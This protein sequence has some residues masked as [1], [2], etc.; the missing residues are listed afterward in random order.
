MNKYYPIDC[1]KIVL[2]LIILLLH[3]R[4]FLPIGDTVLQ[5]AFYNLSVPLF[6]CFSGFFFARNINCK[7]S[8]HHLGVLYLIW[9]VVLWPLCISRFKEIDFMDRIIF[10][11][12]SGFVPTGWFIIALMWCMAITTLIWKIKDK[13]IA[14]ALLTVAGIICFTYCSLRN[15]YS[16][17]EVGQLLY[18]HSQETNYVLGCLFWSFPRG[19]LYFV[20]G[21]AF[22]RLQININRIAAWIAV[23]AIL[24]LFIFETQH[25]ID[26]YRLV[27]VY[28]PLSNPLLVS[29][30]MA[31][32]LSYCRPTP[33]VA[34]GKMLRE[35]S[36]MLYMAH[37]IIMYTV[38]RL[39]GIRIGWMFA[40]T[41]LLLFAIL[42][43]SYLLL[44]NR[45]GF[46]FLKYAV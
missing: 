4:S 6:F 23:I 32:L 46:S 22:M 20:I 3:T 31:L 2:A 17:T 39:T 19:M 16:Q 1:A 15:A 38:S 25:I 12:T 21:F 24:V 30:I 28:A 14:A 29:A 33:H 18:G 35:A 9:L 41:I 27:N 43:Y 11:V 36:T 26:S 44:R 7:K 42:F 34:A 45:K 13:R 37:P 8:L 40:A 5:E 10:L